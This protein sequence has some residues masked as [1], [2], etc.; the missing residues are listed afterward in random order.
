[1]KRA[2][3]ALFSSALVAVAS[4]GMSFSPASAQSIPDLPIPALPAPPAELKPVFGAPSPLVFQVCQAETTVLSLAQAAYT[5]GGLPVNPG[6]VLSQV[7]EVS[8]LG[9]A[10]GYFRL[11]VVPPRCSI[12]DNIPALPVTIPRPASI[13][14]SQVRAIEKSLTQLGAPL[15]RELSGPVYE[16]LGC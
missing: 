3:F 12:D 11:S 8:P 6:L 9:I 7:R 1:M 15:N 5:I 13:T 14:A 4:I 16:Q 10:C 2:T